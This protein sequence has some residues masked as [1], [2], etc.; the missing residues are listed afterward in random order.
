MMIEKDV[1]MQFKE[2]HQRI[3]QIMK[4]KVYEYGIKFGQ[5]HLMMLIDMYPESSQKEIA[6]EMRFTQGA[7]STM[8]KRLMDMK[9]IEQI[10]LKSDM[11]YNRLILTEKGQSIIDDY[12]E[13]LYIKYRDMFKGF[14]EEE[15]EQLNRF[16]TKISNNLDSI[17]KSNNDKNL[18]E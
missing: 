9:M 16:S 13:D 11:R 4:Q 6:K 14:S 2:I 10:P 8:V 12:K 17:Y 5:L 3:A 1:A 18:E 15:L 7:M